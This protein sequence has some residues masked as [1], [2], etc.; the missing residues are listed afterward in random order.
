MPNKE[1]APIL[2]TRLEQMRLEERVPGGRNTRRSTPLVRDLHSELLKA[3]LGLWDEWEVHMI[4]EDYG[5]IDDLACDADLE[6][7][8]IPKPF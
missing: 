3:F 8:M 1:T 5:I 4:L 6:W 2:S 7:L